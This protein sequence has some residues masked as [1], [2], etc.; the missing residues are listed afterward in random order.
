MHVIYA[1]LKALYT[2]RIQR[3]TFTSN[4]S[5]HQTTLTRS[6]H[7]LHCALRSLLGLD[8]CYSPCV[9]LFAE[10]HRRVIAF[11]SEANDTEREL[12]PDLN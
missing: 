8:W 10:A 11:E 3:F 6:T 4:S 1:K 5:P 2:T 12:K 7:E 9:E